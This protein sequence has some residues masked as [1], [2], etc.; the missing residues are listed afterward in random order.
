ML[1]FCKPTLPATPNCRPTHQ[2]REIRDCVTFV[3]IT[4]DPCLSMDT[5]QIHTHLPTTWLHRTRFQDLLLPS[6]CDSPERPFRIALADHTSFVNDSI[7][8]LFTRDSSSAFQPAC[9]RQSIQPRASI[10]FTAIIAQQLFRDTPGISS[11]LQLLLSDWNHFPRTSLHRLTS[12]TDILSQSSALHVRQ[13]FFCFPS[14][15]S[16]LGTTGRSGRMLMG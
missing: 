7:R 5:R 14:F 9:Q 11:G 1:R 3:S 15:N 8:L 6:P 10:W 16:Y 12:R 2:K 13:I 4:N